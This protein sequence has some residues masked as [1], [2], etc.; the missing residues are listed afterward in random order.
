MILQ[1][2][3]THQHMNEF[4]LF[5]SGEQTKEHQGVHCPEA[6]RRMEADLKSCLLGL[7]TTLFGKGGDCQVWSEKD[8]LFV[9]RVG[10]RVYVTR[11]QCVVCGLSGV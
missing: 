1:L 11:E 6:V 2:Y 7:A 9:A 4:R 10:C 8:M 3:G 5:Q